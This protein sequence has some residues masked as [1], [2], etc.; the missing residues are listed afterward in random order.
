MLKEEKAGE[1]EEKRNYEEQYEKYLQLKMKEYRK[2]KQKMEFIG[3]QLKDDHK[4]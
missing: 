3:N 1:D 4:G 2:I